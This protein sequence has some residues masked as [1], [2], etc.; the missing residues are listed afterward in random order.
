MYDS[1]GK[2]GDSDI[3]KPKEK[4]VSREGKQLT[5]SQT[6]LRES[7]DKNGQEET[8]TDK[9]RQE[10]TRTKT[11]FVTMEVLDIDDQWNLNRMV[12][13]KSCWNKW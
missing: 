10:R 9:N 11:A 7:V 12:G 5:A 3:Q 1:G 8:R 13:E 4:N 6:V 2:T